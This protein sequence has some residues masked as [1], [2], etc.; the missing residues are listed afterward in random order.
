LTEAAFEIFE[1]DSYSPNQAEAQIF[2]VVG[3]VV[4]AM[5][6]IN[7]LNLQLSTQAGG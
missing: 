7:Y 2:L 3:I 6:W 5:A 1:N 4:L